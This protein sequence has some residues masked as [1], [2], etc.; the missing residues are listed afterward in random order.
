MNQPFLQGNITITDNVNM[1][2]DLA[3]NP[4]NG[5]MIVNLDEFTEFQG[6]NV[7]GGVAL[8][9][10]PEAIMAQV[11]GDAQSYE[12]IYSNYFYNEPYIRTFM[13][14]IIGYLHNGGSIIF[15]YPSLD[16]NESPT[17]Q[18]LL[19]MIYIQYGIGIGIVGVSDCK[20]NFAYLGFWVSLLYLENIISLKDFIKY[21]PKEDNIDYVTMDK[22][23]F[24]IAPYGETFEE[25][26]NYIKSFIRKVKDKPNLKQG[27]YKC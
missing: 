6:N 16:T 7:I 15:Y 23:I 19:N 13:S 2:T 18:T 17:I 5:I 26:A 8:L 25:Q 21:F 14:A 10:P 27:I 24:E 22:L 20:Y 12:M 1:V 9:P 3:I 11:D 4:P